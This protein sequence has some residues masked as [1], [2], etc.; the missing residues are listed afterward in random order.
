M[1]QNSLPNIHLNL[2]DKF[3]IFKSNIKSINKEIYNRYVKLSKIIIIYNCNSNEFSL[4]L[5]KTHKK[6]FACMRFIFVIRGP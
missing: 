4:S 5:L 6:D 1:P 3:Q 2:Q